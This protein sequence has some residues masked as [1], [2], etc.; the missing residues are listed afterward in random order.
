MKLY[1]HTISD[2]SIVPPV[3]EL[4]DENKSL[5]DLKIIA[6]NLAHDLTKNIDEL[7]WI[8]SDDGNK[9]HELTI[10]SKFRF[11]IRA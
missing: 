4:I 5:D 10:D 2:E 6:M 9:Y 1:K 8:F 3:P 11:V 7:I